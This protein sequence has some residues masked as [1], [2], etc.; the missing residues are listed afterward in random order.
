MDPWRQYRPDPSAAHA[1][2]GSPSAGVRAWRTCDRPCNN[3]PPLAA[4]STVL[5]L[6]QAVA[7]CCW[8][9]LR[10]QDAISDALS[11]RAPRTK[12]LPASD[13]V[14]S[15]GAPCCQKELL[16]CRC[17][18]FR[19]GTTFGTTSTSDIVDRPDHHLPS[20]RQCMARRG[21]RTAA[22]AVLLHRCSSQRSKPTGPT[23][24]QHARAGL[25][26]LLGSSQPYVLCYA[27]LMRQHP[28]LDHHVPVYKNQIS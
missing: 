6:L 27:S 14:D 5:P 15:S 13:F 18:T 28:A 11:P 12:D 10:D 23:I 4:R 9:L 16:E 20:Q 21:C 26:T 22:A 7:V 8:L 1:R 19:P 2:G 25:L 24:L 17:A 3:G